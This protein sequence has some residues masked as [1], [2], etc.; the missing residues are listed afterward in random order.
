[1]LIHMAAQHQLPRDNAFRASLSYCLLC[2]RCESVCLAGLSP[3]D[4]TIHARHVAATNSRPSLPKRLIH[5]AMVGNRALIA[6]LIGMAAVLPGVSNHNGRPM[7]HLVEAASLLSGN[8]SLPTGA[9]PSF[10]RSI[11]R[12]AN[13]AAGVTA[14]GRIAIF[15]GCVF[16]FF[17]AEMARDM[18]TALTR[19][20][21]E[22][23]FPQGLS[24]C[25]QAVYSDGDFKTA[26]LMAERNIRVLSNFDRV[27]TG[28]ATCGSALKGYADWFE[29]D[30]PLQAHAA[31]LARRSFDF[32]EL[33]AE[34]DFQAPGTAIAGET[35]T[36][37]DPCHL[38]WHQGIRKSP[39]RLLQSIPGVS[40][41]EMDG[42]DACCGLGGA[43]GLN[44]RQNGLRR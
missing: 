19:A 17:M 4:I 7:R 13:P 32:T 14:R 38:R 3:A 30:S 11:P 42:A 41:R 39:R 21:F 37:H 34:V 16:E 18:I 9:L 22:V 23:F 27:V 29:K 15:P 44:H 33:L 1:M 25:G 28:C 24:C 12:H 20:G 10:F 2:R 5:R 36:Y 6:K 43:F 35:V 8:L 26:R 40:Y 31:D